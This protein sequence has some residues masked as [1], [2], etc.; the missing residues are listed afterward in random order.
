MI[1]TAS[2]LGDFGG[3]PQCGHDGR[4]VAGV[5]GQHLALLWLT[6]S[7]LRLSQRT[8]LHPAQLG[9]RANK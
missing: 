9:R 3:S 2:V 6:L 5:Y 8:F 7:L 1:G 4:L